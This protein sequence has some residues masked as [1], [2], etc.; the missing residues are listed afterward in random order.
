MRRVVAAVLAGNFLS[1][2]L[3]ATWGWLL[4]SQ[5]RVG[6]F[7][8]EGGFNMPAGKMADYGDPSRLLGHGLWLTTWVAAP[9]ICLIVGI[10][11]GLVVRKFSLSAGI[12]GELLVLCIVVLP[13][14]ITVEAVSAV[15]LYVVCGSLTM[16]AAAH[17]PWGRL[18]SEGR[19]SS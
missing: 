11:L 14:G 4:M 16:W 19:V 18:E 6:Q 2:A 5:T 12:F 8:R 13:M 3:L 17:L 15:I 7:F 1:G 9:A 10:V